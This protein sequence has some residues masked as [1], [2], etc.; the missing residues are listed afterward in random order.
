MVW[1]VVSAIALP[2]ELVTLVNGI[3]THGRFELPR[4][5]V[6]AEL[7]RLAH[8]HAR[9][10]L[11]IHLPQHDHQFLRLVTASKATHDRH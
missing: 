8:N 4:R 9:Y 5:Q 7:E 2:F 1:C 10:R 3:S 6:V 11:P